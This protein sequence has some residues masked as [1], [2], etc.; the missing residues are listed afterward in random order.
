MLLGIIWCII[1]VNQAKIDLSQS[2]S[3]WTSTYILI[4]YIFIWKTKIARI[5]NDLIFFWGGGVKV[6]ES[7]KKI[8]LII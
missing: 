6:T 4:I 7:D 3:L 2:V 5:I 8:I 1:F